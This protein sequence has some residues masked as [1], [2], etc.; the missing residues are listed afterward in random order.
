MLY[1]LIAR[2]VLIAAVAD[3][4]YEKKSVNSEFICP[5]SCIMGTFFVCLLK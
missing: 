1:I 5:C 4:I 2:K 3:R